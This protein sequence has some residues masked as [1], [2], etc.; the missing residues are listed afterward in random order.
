MDTQSELETHNSRATDTNI[1][2]E[3]IKTIRGANQIQGTIVDLVR[4]TV[5]STLRAAGFDRG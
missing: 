4:N 3:L 1:K 5:S 2:Q